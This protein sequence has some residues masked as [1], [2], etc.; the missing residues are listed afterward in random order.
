MSPSHKARKKNK[1][2]VQGNSTS[3]E[4][5]AVP[6]PEL[7]WP[8]E[9]I[10]A[11]IHQ[12]YLDDPDLREFW[13][14]EAQGI[15][16]AVSQ[17]GLALPKDRYTYKSV[18]GVG[19]SG[20]VLRLSDDIFI[21]LDN[22]LKFPRPVAGKIIPVAE[23]LA[24][25]MNFLAELR[26]PGIVRILYYCTVENVEVYGSLPFYLMEAVDGLR[27]D[28]YVLEI[29]KQYEPPLRESDV[30]QLESSL[31]TLFR[32]VLDTLRYLHAHPAGERAHLDVKP[33]N[34]VVDATGQPIMIDLGTC[35]RILDDQSDTIVACTLSMAAPSLARLL[36]KDPTDENRA[37]GSVI[38]SDISA[39]WDLWAFGISI[40]RWLGIDPSDGKT[41]TE[42]IA[43]LITSY[44]RKFLLL[45]VAR[46]FANEKP[47]DMRSWICERIGLSKTLL[48]SMAVASAGE[49]LELLARLDNTSNP[50]SAVRELDIRSVTT[51][52]PSEGEHVPLTG[53]LID[54]LGHPLL[55]RLDSIA[56]LGLVVEVFPEARHTRKEHSLGTYAYVKEYLLALYSDPV[57]PL[58]KQWITPLDC[59]DVLLS[60]LLHDI[61]HFPLAH[62]LEDIDDDLFDHSDLTVAMLRGAFDKKKIGSTRIPFTSLEPVLEQWQ[63]SAERIVEILTAKAASLSDSVRPK[64][65][66]LRSFISGAIDA[67]KMDYLLRDGDRM[68]LPYPRG[69]DVDRILKSLTVVVVEK[70]PGG[71]HDVP[72]V[73]VHAKGKVA[74]EFVSIARYAMFSQG[75]WH[76]AVRAMKAMLT[77][78]V[79]ALIAL[80]TD[81]ERNK[82]QSS[83]I[84]FATSL[85]E[86]LYERTPTQISLL[87][88][89]HDGAN[90]PMS[91]D[92]PQLATTD[93]AT[94]KWFEQRLETKGR[95][96]STLIGGIL[97]RKL[98]KR[99]WVVS[100]DMEQTLWDQLIGLW[101]GLAR[102]KRFEAAY[103]FEKLILKRLKEKGLKSI[104]AFPSEK[105]DE[106]LELRLAARIPWLLIDIPGSRPGSDVGLF[107]VLE[108]QRRQ[109]R[110]DEKV[111]GTIQA[112]D[113][114]NQYASG[115]LAAGGK[116]RVFCDPSLVDAID[117][118]LEWQQGIEELVNALVIAKG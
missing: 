23:M 2:Q 103:E 4:I 91:S 84:E 95:P 85:P 19:G 24:K 78:A 58:F 83:F 57:S 31:L 109:L 65:K 80:A 89:A 73:G 12:S 11:D 75:Y 69:I 62:D 105:T 13:D 41:K 67:D 77:R 29:S 76:H 22:A 102:Q 30:S 34:I 64:A 3:E 116:I 98:F 106:E 108:G 37:G 115:L 5:I 71:A 54:L 53:P 90:P 66:L 93:V 8:T 7:R 49:A 32:N 110:K 33:E 55:K 92:V 36:G 9:K 28:K 56:Q 118:S 50:I 86:S 20:I 72:L 26:H 44:S 15:G 114:W 94:L 107:Y 68:H 39:T 117:A 35:K 81:E 47:E 27:S 96:E 82:F 45:L 97:S 112:S 10:I 113:V 79:Q 40:L 17:I 1:K 18:M 51:M 21:H 60:A 42:A 101:S 88:P 52:Q 70:L 100:R 48:R 14:A 63:T 43:Y 74:A 46:L 61:G 87:D 104:T 25:E 16:V 99:L 6:T 59:R 38:R 111:S